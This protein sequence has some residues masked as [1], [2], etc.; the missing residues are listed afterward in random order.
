MAENYKEDRKG[1]DIKK[2]MKNKLII[3]LEYDNHKFDYIIDV[4]NHKLAKFID[5]SLD[6][7]DSVLRNISSISKYGETYEETDEDQKVAI[8]NLLDQLKDG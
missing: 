8:D 1:Q 2:Y 4:N 7:F 6:V 3:T 5:D